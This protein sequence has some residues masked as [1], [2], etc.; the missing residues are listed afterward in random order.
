L[1]NAQTAQNGEG[2]TFLGFTTVN[3]DSNG[4]ASFSVPLSVIVADGAFITAT[5]TDPRGNT[6]EFGV[7]VANV[8]DAVVNQ[9]PVASFVA[10]PTAGTAPLNVNFDASASSDPDGNI[11][12]YTWDF[13][14]GNSAS[15]VNAGNTYSLPGN[16]TVKL[17]VTDDQGASNESNQVITVDP[18]IGGT[19]VELCPSQDAYLQN[20]SLFNNNLIRLENGSRQR[21]GYLQYDL[22]N[23]NGQVTKAQLVL[24]V[25][26]A[27][28]GGDAGSGQIQVFLGDS[29]AWNENNL[30]SNT[31]GKDGAP[32]GSLNNSYTLG[33][34]YTFDL[35]VARL[36]TGDALSLILE[37]NANGG[38]DVAFASDENPQ[39]LCPT[40]ILEIDSQGNPN[41]DPVASF[42][43][44]PT[45]GTTPLNVS[46]NA[47]AST[48]PDG[49]IV[50]Y[51]WDFG[52]GNSATGVNVNN[53]Y[54]APGSYTARLTVTDDQGASAES[55]Q[56][57]T[58]SPS[59]G[60]RTAELCPV[61]DAYLENGQ[62]FNNALIRLENGSR[63]RVGY[64]QYDLSN[65]SGTI[66]S[67]Q[68][69]L[70]VPNQANGGDAGSGQIQIFLGDSNAWNEGNLA[71][72]TPGKDGLALGSLNTSYGLGQAFS[73]NLDANRLN[74]GGILSFILESNANGGNDVA[75]G[76]EEN[77]QALC[78]TLILELD[79]GGNPPAGSR[80]TEFRLINA[81]SD[82][83]LGPLNNN[84]LLAPSDLG[85]RFLSVQ[86]ITDPNEVGSVVFEL[87]G[88]VSR[89]QTENIL[90]YALFGDNNG[91]YNGVNLPD[92]TYTL[93]A[94]PYSGKKASGVAGTPLSIVFTISPFALNKN[95]QAHSSNLYPNPS[96]GEVT[97]DLHL[98]AQEKAE[99]FVYDNQGQAM[100]QKEAQG[101]EKLYF[102]NLSPGIYLIRVKQDDREKLMRLIVK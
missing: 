53:T 98:E 33:Q 49:T 25:P 26:N 66:T 79:G 2:E 60:G 69:K 59:S 50:T 48:D 18:E 39:A 70:T 5:A 100:Q 92:G 76:S 64:L 89:T 13:G 83:D 90:P 55:T 34:S 81:Q 29:N 40:L 46:F 52:D 99:V 87:T 95:Y 91:D 61:E 32:L 7:C 54:S 44:T 20:G 12:A 6:S 17:T 77:V 11:V 30:A 86:A 4:D 42:Q 47:S 21:V 57:I 16:Y 36:I 45:S 8:Q 31:P 58:V 3:T 88:P 43:A 35:N 80:V 51:A 27:A 63:Q 74:S 101:T 62:L 10:S 19:R 96:K 84:V 22:S 73:F 93:S 94:T 65:L 1:G 68:L 82:Q 15:G 78:P 72:N 75:F 37:S 41:Q 28:N 23:L 9:F 71:S 38:N 56:V 102:Q 85:T 67:A 24:T 97:L 14:D